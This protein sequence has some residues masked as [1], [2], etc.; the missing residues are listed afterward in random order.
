M[1]GGFILLRKRL[2]QSAVAVLLL[3]AIVGVPQGAALAS[4]GRGQVASPL[5]DTSKTYFKG[6]AHK[7]ID[8]PGPST[9]DN[10]ILDIYTCIETASNERWDLSSHGT[11]Y[12]FK[13]Q[14]SHKCM[15]V[16]GASKADGA[17]VLQYTCLENTNAEWGVGTWG[18]IG[19]FTYYQ[20]VNVNSGKCLTVENNGTANNSKLVQY[21]CNKGYNQAW[22]ALDAD[23]AVG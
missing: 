23:E 4:Q 15:T 17:F 1:N 20:I 6:Y 9:A 16:K 12:W 8:N 3:G 14:Y 10:T 11:A 21:T 22:I 18:T 19:G 13:N 7:C 2:F 5:V